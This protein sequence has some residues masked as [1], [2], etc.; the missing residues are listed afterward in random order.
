MVAAALLPQLISPEDPQRHRQA[1]RE[2]AWPL[3]DANG[4]VSASTS[5]PGEISALAECC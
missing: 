2:H 4:S 3:Y 5:E 1:L